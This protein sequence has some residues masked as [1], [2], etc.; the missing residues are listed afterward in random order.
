[1]GSAPHEADEVSDAP[2]SHALEQEGTSQVLPRIPLAAR[3]PREALAFEQGGQ[4]LP[5]PARPSSETEPLFGSD[6]AER[7]ASGAP[8]SLPPALAR[9]GRYEVIGRL[10]VGGMAEIYLARES[11]ETGALRHVAIKVLKQSENAA[12]NDGYFDELFMREGRTAAQLVHPNICHV[13]EFGK[14]EGYFYIAMEWIEGA[15]L[16]RVLTKLA[17]RGNT[18]PPALAVGIAAQVAGA[19]HYAHNVRDARRKPLQVVHLDVNPQNIMLRHD[20]V[21][22]LLDFGIA[23]V[24]EPRDDT[25]S[26]TVKGK[27]GYIAPEQLRR[28]TLDRRVDV[29]GLGAVLFEMLTGRPAY[30]NESLRECADALLTQPPPSIRSVVPHLP[31]ELEEIVYKAL[32]LEP[33]DRF[34]TAG[35]LQ[36]A[37][38]GY[39]ARSREVV[40]SRHIAQ[41]MESVTPSAPT[42]SPQLY[43]GPEVAT[44]LAARTRSIDPT[45]EPLGTRGRWRPPARLWI[46]AAV[47]L[48][49]VLLALFSGGPEQPAR[50]V[51]T[52]RSPEQLAPAPAAAPVAPEVA[53]PA[54]PAALPRSA[55]PPAA[56]SKARAAKVAPKEKRVTRRRNKPDFV[57]DPGF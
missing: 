1:M 53:E 33:A 10:A 55:Q 22:K 15:P 3:I 51:A 34:Q 18:M 45:G 49:A 14:V 54:A 36:A 5:K 41:L 20:G 16:R 39:L 8:P 9:V 12:E 35:E 28:Q 26:D 29:F 7:V 46:A 23:Q 11:V 56:P 52:P 25:R 27:L 47:V 2:P 44:R 21:V 17:K 50:V 24:A 30:P 42:G 40:S 37:L 32:A 13:Y 43:R 19:L 38:E 31:P 57:A 48:I 4:S 6:D